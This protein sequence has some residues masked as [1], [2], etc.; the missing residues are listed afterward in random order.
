[1][2][3]CCTLLRVLW[4]NVRKAFALFVF[5]KEHKTWIF[6]VI[7]PKSPFDTFIFKSVGCGHGLLSR[8]F[9]RCILEG[10]ILLLLKGGPSVASSVCA[11]L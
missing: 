3:P 2:R 8:A 10:K 5:F 4:G 9:T 7:T 1:M 11:G 6:N